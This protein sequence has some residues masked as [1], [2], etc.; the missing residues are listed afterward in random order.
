MKK[1]KLLS[2]L[3]S[4]FAFI[5]FCADMVAFADET[6]VFDYRINADGTATIIGFK[7]NDINIVIPETVDA[8][9]VTAIGDYAFSGM[10]GIEKLT[11]NAEIT[12]IGNSAF[13]G[14]TSLKEVEIPDTVT[15]IGEYAFG[16]CPLLIPDIIPDS[17][18]NKNDKIFALRDDIADDTASSDTES[19]TDNEN[20]NTPIIVMLVIVSAFSAIACGVCVWMFVKSKRNKTN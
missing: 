18:Q 12:S 14:C 10:N 16:N 13:Y 11:I 6:N 5:F 19:E 7:A 8:Y 20:D 4:A 2:V 17:V 1:L 15:Q 9:K 3:L